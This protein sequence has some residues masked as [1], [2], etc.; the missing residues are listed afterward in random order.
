MNDIY[1]GMAIPKYHMCEASH[2]ANYN[3]NYQNSVGC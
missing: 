2:Y 1:I 3:Y